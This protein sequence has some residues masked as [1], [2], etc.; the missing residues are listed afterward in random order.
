[1]S[2]SGTLRCPGFRDDL[3]PSLGRPCSASTSLEAWTI[4]SCG[5][6][7]PSGATR[8][9]AQSS[10]RGV[11]RMHATHGAPGLLLSRAEALVTALRLR[12]HEGR[13]AAI[14]AHRNSDELAAF[15]RP[16]WQRW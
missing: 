2:H 9:A 11:R 14:L 16:R 1:M 4:T 10:S 13:I 15:G 12:V 3:E 8:V 7:A 6:N 5:T